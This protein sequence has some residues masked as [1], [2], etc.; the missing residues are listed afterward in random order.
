MSAAVFSSSKTFRDS[1]AQL[2]PVNPDKL[3]PVLERI[4]ETLHFKNVAPF[5]PE[6]LQKLQK[7]CKTDAAGVTA[8]IDCCSYIFEQF[9]YHSVTSSDAVTSLLNEQGLGADKCDLIAEVWGT[10][11]KQYLQELRHRSLGGPLMLKQ[12]ECKPQVGISASAEEV[13]HK[14]NAVLQLVLG[15]DEESS[16]RTEKLSAQ[17]SHKQL[18]DFFTKLETIQT[19]LD[20]LLSQ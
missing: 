2:N 12:V 3:R 13:Q 10:Y 1:V 4:V 9:A 16:E 5:T 18:Y 14:P 19:Q 7:V 15:C 8:V 6:E 17:L 20:G 11:G